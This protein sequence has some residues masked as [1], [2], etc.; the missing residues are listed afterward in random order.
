[1]PG[2]VIIFFIILIIVVLLWRPGPG[3]NSGKLGPQTTAMTQQDYFSGPAEVQPLRPL[4]FDFA[5][6]DFMPSKSVLKKCGD[7]CPRTNN[8]VKFAE[9]SH[10]RVMDFSTGIIQEEKLVPT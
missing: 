2:E 7:D 8:H 9:K 1:M 10:T 4:E 5:V 6:D 3:G